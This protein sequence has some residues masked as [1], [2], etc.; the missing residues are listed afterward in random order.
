MVAA[1]EAAGGKAIAVKCDPG[2]E[3]EVIGLFDRGARAFGTIEASSKMPASPRRPPALAEMGIERIRRVVHVNLTGAI[4]S[5]GK[6]SAGWRRAAAAGRRPRQRSSAAAKLGAPGDDV[7]YAAAK[8]ASSRRR[9][10]VEEV[11]PDGMR[12]VGGAPAAT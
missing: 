7:D 6:A 11:G 10:L 8:E 12:V 5:P 2:V 9:R 3:A 1:V 4:S